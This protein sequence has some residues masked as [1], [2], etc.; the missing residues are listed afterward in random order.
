MIHNILWILV[1][2][3]HV[4]VLVLHW[5]NMKE[6]LVH[7]VPLKG[8]LPPLVSFLAR[9][10]LFLSRHFSQASSRFSRESLMR[11]VW[12]ILHVGN[13]L[14]VNDSMSNRWDKI[15]IDRLFDSFR[16]KV[17]SNVTNVTR[18]RVLCVSIHAITG[19]NGRFCESSSLRMIRTIQ[20]PTIARSGITA[21]S[22]KHLILCRNKMFRPSACAGESIVYKWES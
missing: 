19:A 12:H 9:R 1:I 10:V 8:K 6:K 7:T 3:I 2:Y 5:L 22:N 16:T 4:L 13:R 17:K 15:C 21:N 14:C 11:L 18:S 20:P